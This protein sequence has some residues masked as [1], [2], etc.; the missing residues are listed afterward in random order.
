MDEKDVMAIFKETGFTGRLFHNRKAAL[1]WMAN[2]DGFMRVCPC[3]GDPRWIHLEVCK[4]HR[5]EGD[6]H[7]NGCCGAKSDALL[8]GKTG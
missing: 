4:W 2:F 7:C 5:E 6:P 3:E 8:W 1:K